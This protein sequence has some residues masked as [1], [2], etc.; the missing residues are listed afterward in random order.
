MLI[1]TTRN[2]A[3]ACAAL[4]AMAAPAAAAGPHDGDWAGVM[5]AGPQTFHMVLHLKTDKDGLSAEMD[6]VDQD[7]TIPS[8]AIKTDGPKMSIL[9]MAVAGELEGEFSADN[10][11]FVGAWKQGLALPL[12][13]TRTEPAPAAAKP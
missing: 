9:F 13:L 1:R 5:K 11:T 2:L 10:K 4:L 6:S 8:S 7:I 3:L 12:T